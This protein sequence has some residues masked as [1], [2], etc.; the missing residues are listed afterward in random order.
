MSKMWVMAVFLF[1]LGGFFYSYECKL[2]RL[3]GKQ[4]C[5]H[6]SPGRR[7]AADGGRLLEGTRQTN[8]RSDGT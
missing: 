7:E 4:R 3:E 1:V 8:K 6:I 5:I 2:S